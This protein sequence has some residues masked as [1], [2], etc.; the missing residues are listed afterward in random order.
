MWIVS[1]KVE[2][3]MRRY[4]GGVAVA[5]DVKKNRVHH[6]KRKSIVYSGSVVLSY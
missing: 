3:D 5:D 6:D 4:G 2:A 1:G